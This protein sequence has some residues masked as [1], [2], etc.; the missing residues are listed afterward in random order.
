MPS[1]FQL[2]PGRDGGR[3][4]INELTGCFQFI[5]AIFFHLKAQQEKKKNDVAL[6]CR[7]WTS[8]LFVCVHDASS[9]SVCACMCVSCEE[10]RCSTGCRRDSLFQGCR[11]GAERTI[12]APDCFSHTYCGRLRYPPAIAVPFLAKAA[13]GLLYLPGKRKKKPNTVL[14]KE[15]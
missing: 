3:Q 4:P 1:S 14:L 10:D 13:I 8:D 5:A 15:K 9:V 12:T 6:K 11:L 7:S 2:I